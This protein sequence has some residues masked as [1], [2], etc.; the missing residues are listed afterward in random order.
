[1]ARIAGVDIPNDKR[2]EIGLTYI[3]GIGPSI[4]KKIIKDTGVDPDRRCREL[5]D[6]DVTRI[7]RAIENCPNVL[8]VFAAHMHMRS[9]DPIGDKCQFLAPPGHN[10]EWRYVTIA[11]T[12]PPKFPRVPGG[13]DVDPDGDSH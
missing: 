5:T 13:P 2:V 1:M 7:R 3:Y 10:G 8:G 6:D 11:N 4:S 9:E 12:P